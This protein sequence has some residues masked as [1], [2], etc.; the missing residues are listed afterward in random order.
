[1]NAYHKGITLAELV[2]ATAIV[3]LIG[4]ALAGFQRD[5]FFLNTTTQNNLSAQMESRRVLKTMIAELRSATRSSLGAYPVVSAGTSS[6]VFFS[7]IDADQAVERIRY[8]LQG[9]E[10][11]RGV[12]KPSGNP[13]TYNPAQ[14]SI[15]VVIRDVS[16]NPSS[17]LF[18][19][20]SS[21]YAG[22]TSALT[23]PINVNQ[24]R[25]VRVSVTIDKDSSRPPGPITAQSQAMLRNLKD[26]Q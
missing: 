20:F 8:F 2:I 13:L 1:M 10:L 22:T 6:L 4:V 23:Y 17:P 25:L 12:I 24:I 11:R 9:R 3:L 7:N 21:T 26:N 19:Y 15:G 5:I 14:E 16:N 18:Y